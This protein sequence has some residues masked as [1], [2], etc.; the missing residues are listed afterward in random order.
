MPIPY[1]VTQN[2][3]TNPPSYT[4]RPVPRNTLDYDTLAAQINLHNP[5]IPAE[6]AKAVLTRQI[7]VGRW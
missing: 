2:F 3:L 5:T 4:A 7:W 1:K 6:T